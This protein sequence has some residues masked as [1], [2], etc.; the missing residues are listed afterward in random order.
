MFDYPLSV[1]RKTH[2]SSLG[3]DPE[4]TTEEIRE[5]TEEIVI[6]LKR[7]KD[8][9]DRQ[10]EEIYN[11]V[12]GL[13]DAYAQNKTLQAEGA[14]ADPSSVH[15]A[16]KKLAE[17]EQKAETLAPNFRQLRERS[18]DLELKIND[19]HRIAFVNPESRL[20]YEKSMPPL[21][22]LKLASCTRDDF[23]EGKAAVTLLRRELSRF[24]SEL[25]EEAYHPSDLT[26][27]N[28]SSDFLFNPI[29]DRDHE[30]K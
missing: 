6:S 16:K 11:A 28:F 8:A 21:E 20:S 19:I 27:E 26:R 13:K 24:L 29:L 10:I 7:Q 22:L 1:P 5:A 25:G 30:R 14:D 3:L 2:Y 23:T 12:P 9:V 4:A 17:L 15:A 18:S